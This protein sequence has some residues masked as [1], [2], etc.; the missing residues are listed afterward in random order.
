[1]VAFDTILDFNRAQGDKINLRLVDANTAL[2]GDQNFS[3]PLA[4]SDP[5]PVGAGSLRYTVGRSST[6]IEGSTDADAEMEFRIVVLVPG[7]TPI[8]SDFIL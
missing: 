1:L 8:A 6:I 4:A 7:Y 3:A 2:L 5:T